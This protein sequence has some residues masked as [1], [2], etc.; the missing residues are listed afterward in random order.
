MAAANTQ[1]LQII[2][3]EADEFIRRIKSQLGAIIN[4]PN[5]TEIVQN[6]RTELENINLPEYVADSVQSIM[7]DKDTKKIIENNTYNKLIDNI[8]N[9]MTS[10]N[11]NLTDPKP[12]NEDETNINNINLRLQ[13]CQNLELLYLKKHKELMQTFAFTLNLFDKYKY[14]I[15]LLVYILQNI[16]DRAEEAPG[17]GP[18]AVPA[19]ANPDVHIYFRDRQ[20][21]QLR[22]I[23]KENGNNANNNNR[24]YTI[25]RP[26]NQ[27]KIVLTEN[28]PGEIE[29]APQ[30]STG[31]RLPRAIITNMKKLL[32]DQATVQ[33]I[34]NQMQDTI[35]N[36]T[37]STTFSEIPQQVNTN[38]NTNRG[39]NSPVPRE[40]ISAY[41]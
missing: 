10:L 34:I 35:A 1:V 38:T 22:F 20:N 7:I 11:F 6:I 33:K 12:Y 9:K 28:A 29:A 19:A 24:Q 40:N 36:D 23:F 39:Y 41:K 13:N 25:E 17:A 27:I 30:T 21:E 8:E 16:V 14:A 4:E 18:I 37:M 5:I 2:R 15:R 31:I 3:Q 26:N 32:K